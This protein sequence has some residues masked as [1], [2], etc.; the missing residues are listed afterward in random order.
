MMINTIHFMVRLTQNGTI[1]LNTFI[2]SS[3]LPLNKE[4]L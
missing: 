3:A 4:I 1:Q 2:H